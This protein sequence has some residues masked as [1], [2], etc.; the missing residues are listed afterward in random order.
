MKQYNEERM[1]GYINDNRFRNFKTCRHI[2]THTVY[3]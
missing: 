1:A 3:K 2:H